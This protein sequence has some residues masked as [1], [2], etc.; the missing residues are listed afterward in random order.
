MSVC[1]RT[2]VYASIYFPIVDVYIYIY[3]YLYVRIF[4]CVSV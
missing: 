1:A 2:W 3:I 4:A